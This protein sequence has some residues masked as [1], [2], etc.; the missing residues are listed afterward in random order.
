[1]SEK[2]NQKKNVTTT[3]EME[4]KQSKKTKTIEETYKKKSQREHVLIRPDMYIGSIIHET[5]DMWVYDKELN[6]IVKKTISYVPGFYKIIDELIVNARD[7]H[8]RDSKCT[9]IKMYFN[10]NDGSITIWNNGS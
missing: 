8:T 1:M 9:W 5:G 2:I 4:P 7:H 3:K 6:L 10:Q